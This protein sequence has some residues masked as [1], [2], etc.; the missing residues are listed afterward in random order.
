MSVDPGETNDLSP[1]EPKLKESLVK[2][3]DAYAESVG[4]VPSNEGFFLDK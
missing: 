4:V 2:T 3:W 1:K